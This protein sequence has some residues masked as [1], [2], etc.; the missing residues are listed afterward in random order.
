M[1]SN[2]SGDLQLELVTTGEKAGLW[3]TITNNNLQILEL[4]S[5]GYLT[6]AQLG[7]GDLVLALDAGSALGDSTATGKNLMIEV[8]GTLTGDRV[9][10]MPVGAERIFI[11]KD[12]TNRSATSN[13]TIGV[14]NVGASAAGIIPLPVGSTCMFYTNGTTVD[15]MN[16]AGI[17]N[18][19]TVQVQT[20]VNTPYAAVNGDIIFGETAN[21]GGGAIAVNLPVG[22]AGHTVTIMDAST[23]GGFSSFNCTV[24]PNGTEKIQGGVAGAS[25]AL[26]QNNQSV[27]LIYTNASK[28]WQ[29]LS[30]NQ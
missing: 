14:Q 24:S 8:T 11:I 21:S 19:G 9:I 10:T 15:S 27:T 4:S 25:I 26:D 3:G 29:K 16:L 23:S 12:S 1:A 20:A 22:V 13:Y 6:T 17:L 2:Y 7:T 30:N 5:S 28:G 18:K